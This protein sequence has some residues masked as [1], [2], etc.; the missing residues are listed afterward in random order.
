MAD[1]RVEI[2][3]HAEASMRVIARYIE[4]ELKSPQAARKRK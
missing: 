1:Y 4:F 2:T 3:E